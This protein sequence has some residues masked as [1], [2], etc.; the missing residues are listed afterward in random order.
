VT[1]KAKAAAC[2]RGVTETNITNNQVEYITKYAR[3]MAAWA[4]TADDQALVDTLRSHEQSRDD[5][6]DNPSPDPDEFAALTEAA[7]VLREVI[8]QRAGSR[9]G[10]VSAGGSIITFD[11]TPLTD[12]GNAE[13]LVGR[14]RLELRWCEPQRRWYF[15]DGQRW[16][17][18][19]ERRVHQMAKRTAR[20][21]YSEAITAP[22]HHKAGEIAKWAHRSETQTRLAAMVELAK[23]EPGIPIRPEDFDRDPWLLNASSGT[24]D[25]RSGTARAHDRNQF[26]TKLAD[27]PYAP[28]ADCPT[29][30]KF[31]DTIMGGD[32]EIV[33]Y[34]Q[35]CIGYSLTGDISEQCLFICYGTGQNGKSTLLTTL[36]DMLGDYGMQAVKEMLLVRR[37]DGVRN[38]LAKL[39]GVRL[40]VDVETDAGKRLSESLVKQLTGGDRVSARFLYGEFFEFTPQCKIWIATNHRPIIRGTDL[41]IWRRMR[42]IP[43]TVKIPDDQKDTR[44]PEKLREELPGIFRWAVEGTRL[45][46]SEG[47]GMPK[48]VREATDDYQHSMDVVQRWIDE[49]CVIEEDA[50]ETPTHLYQ[51]YRAWCEMEGEK[52]P[53]PLSQNFFGEVLED[54]G[55]PR[56]RNKHGR[57]RAGIRLRT[58]YERESAN[59]NGGVTDDDGQKQ[60]FSCYPLRIE[61]FGFVRHPVSPVASS[62][63]TNPIG[64]SS[65]PI[66]G[67]NYCRTCDQQLKLFDDIASGFCE[68]HRNGGVA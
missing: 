2:P 57:W 5:L 64:E 25:L 62:K 65:N 49:R 27:V 46:L 35:R 41:G 38:D 50:K 63:Q 55:F 8:E 21:I 60:D 29:W 31:L 47:L 30:L 18:D 43:F 22:D 52:E 23:S 16:R 51:D 13:R 56:R 32:Q 67:S 15:Y 6:H 10:T 11:E 4:A 42:L 24:L 36:L 12:L 48:R 53:H 54:K 3:D 68:A 7:Q 40:L 17:V 9:G 20:A 1:L 19:D 39:P 45:W 61:T 37:A 14:F 28:E 66:L 44:L 58:L 26:L 33:R 34:L 59:G